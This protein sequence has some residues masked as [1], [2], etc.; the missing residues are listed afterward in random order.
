MLGEAFKKEEKKKKERR[1]GG[2][3]SSVVEHLLARIKPYVQ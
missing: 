2:S 3:P 1:E